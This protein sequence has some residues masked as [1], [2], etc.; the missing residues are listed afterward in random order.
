MLASHE[1]FL[2]RKHP[3]GTTYAAR[4]KSP[5]FRE[6]VCTSSALSEEPSCET[7]LVALPPAT[8]ATKEYTATAL[9]Y[10]FGLLKLSVTSVY[11]FHV[12][13]E[14]SQGPAI[15]RR[16]ALGLVCALG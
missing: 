5:H 7:A 8:S 6:C 12:P 9:V 16:E 15:T 3:Q 10:Y 11:G 4:D 13:A 2:F 1:T 14:V